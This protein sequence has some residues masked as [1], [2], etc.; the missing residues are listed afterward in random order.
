MKEAQ[1][2]NPSL[3]AKWTPFEKG[4]A[5]KGGSGAWFIQREERKEGKK[6]QQRE[7]EKKGKEV[8]HTCG[9]LGGKLLILEAPRYF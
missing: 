4:G 1:H 3:G 9:V 7:R 2:K 6:G 8:S 5:V